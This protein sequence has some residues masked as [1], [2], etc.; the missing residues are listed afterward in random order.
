ML[1]KETHFRD[2]ANANLGKETNHKLFLSLCKNCTQTEMEDAEAR[3][4][5]MTP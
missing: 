2:D 4:T 5:D 1:Y 3:C